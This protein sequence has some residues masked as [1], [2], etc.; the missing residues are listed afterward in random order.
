MSTLRT[1]AVRSDDHDR[2]VL[3]SERKELTGFSR[4]Y[5]W[6]LE[7]QGL[8]PRRIHFGERRIGWLHSELMAWLRERAAAR[9]A[10]GGD[11][12]PAA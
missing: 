8:V 1:K 12:R 9:D 6:K 10:G 5:W 2:V 3:E 4:G 11:A 7:Q